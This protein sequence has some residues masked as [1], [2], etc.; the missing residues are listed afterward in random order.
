M[1]GD[2]PWGIGYCSEEFFVFRTYCDGLTYTYGR[3]SVTFHITR[4]LTY[5]FQIKIT[6]ETKFAFKGCLT[7]EQARVIREG[8]PVLM[9]AGTPVF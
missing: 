7:T 4:I 8:P 2:I 3:L 6:I 1:I 5:A 9:S